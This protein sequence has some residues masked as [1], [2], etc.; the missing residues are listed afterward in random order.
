MTDLEIFPEIDS[1]KH[2]REA[3][4][5]LIGVTNQSGVA[6]G[7]VNEGF[8]KE[9]N[10]LFIERYGFDDFL[11]CPH[12]P[13]E[14]CPCRKP[15]P[16]MLLRARGKHKVNLK[17]SFVIG[18]KESDMLLAKAA[19]AAGILVQTGQLQA[20]PY[21]DYTAKDLRDAVNWILQ[22]GT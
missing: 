3:G 18:D 9:V 10:K 1:L 17:K 16:D 8:V 14:H 2:L 4:F 5:K 7:I 6:R 13:D 20:S 19:G 15:E 22:K 21:A 11:Y 12:H